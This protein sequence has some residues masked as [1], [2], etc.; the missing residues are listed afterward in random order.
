MTRAAAAGIVL[1]LA[2]ACRHP[3]K[4]GTPA[5]PEEKAAARKGETRAQKGVPP[6]GAR[7]RVP[8]SPKALLAEGEIGKIQDALAQRG[9]LEQHHPGALDDPTTK[10]IRR[11]QKDE[12]LAETGFP[13]RLTLQELGLDPEEAYGKVRDEVKGEGSAGAGEKGK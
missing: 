2:A 3:S 4:V 12:G 7:P 10:A 13:D 5:P 1:L 8:A 11:F 6:A 9:Y